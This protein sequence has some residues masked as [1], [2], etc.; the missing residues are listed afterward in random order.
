MM[1]ER[2]KNDLKIHCTINW[3]IIYEILEVGSNGCWDRLRRFSKIVNY[4]W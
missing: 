2:L 3:W 4:R 1:P